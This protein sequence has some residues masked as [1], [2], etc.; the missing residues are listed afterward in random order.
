M[1]GFWLA[2]AL[3]GC[4][5]GGEDKPHGEGQEQAEPV[6]VVEMA[7]ASSGT[8]IDEIVSSA[9][10]EALAQADLVPEATGVVVQIHKDEGDPVTKGEV[11][12]VLDN[13]V[14]GTGAERARGEVSRLEQQ[15]NEARELLQ[16]GAISNRELEDLEHQ[17]NTARLSA[18]EASRTWGQT[19]L[20]APFDGVVAMRGIQMGE[21]ASGASVAFQ[22]VDPSQLRVVAALPERDLARISVGQPAR[23]MSAYDPEHVAQGRVARIAP[24]VDASSGTFRVTVE[25]EPGARLRPGQFVSVRLQV[26]EHAGVLVVPKQAVV[27]E[28]GTPVVYKVGPP[29]EKK[30]GED[31][32]KEEAPEGFRFQLPA[33]LAGGSEE[34]GEGED[35]E[36]EDQGPP[37]VAVRTRV[38]LALVDEQWAEVKTGLASGDKVVVVGQSN[39]RDGARVREAPPPGEAAKAGSGDQG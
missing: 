18:R 12:A 31:E 36:K 35:K 28:D 33:W 16:R 15:V 4:S 17:L 27:W 26:D 2:L 5:G 24:V 8:V 6:T 1:S 11:L 20:V 22:I 10:V 7:M 30:E 34:E 25:V 3:A 32:K 29:P 38:E 39:L 13:A 37:L 9:V 23:L 19:R 21:L 14:L